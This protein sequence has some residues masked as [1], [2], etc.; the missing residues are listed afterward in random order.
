MS[1]AEPAAG[2]REA[3]LAFWGAAGAAEAASDT[4]S[5]SGGVAM[6]EGVPSG[7]AARSHRAASRRQLHAQVQLSQRECRRAPKVRLL[8]WLRWCRHI[9]CVCHFLCYDFLLCDGLLVFP[10]W[11]VPSER[12]LRLLLQLSFCAHAGCLWQ[13][14][15]LR[16]Q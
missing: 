14:L 11:H 5:Y 1:A 7:A 15:R 2:S 16:L 6:G 8:P 4:A 12:S 13:Q 9:P 3:S 10:R